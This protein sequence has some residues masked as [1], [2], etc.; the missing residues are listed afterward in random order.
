M[1]IDYVFGRGVSR[2]LPL[3]KLDL[4][5]SMRTSKLKMISS[6]GRHVASF[7]SDGGITLSVYGA[8]LLVKSRAF[9]DNCVV[10]N[11]D[12]EEFVLKGR[13]VFA[14]H[15]VNCGKRVRPA[16]EVVVLSQSGKVLGVGKAIMS[17]RMIE[18][19]NSGVA[20]KVRRS[21]AT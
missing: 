17:S 10:V 6:D 5:F 21:A 16:S 15:V 2:R 4:T 14:K 8:E 12:A 18:D 1:S 20:V 9:R 11:Q 7:R 19:F 13:S 3:K